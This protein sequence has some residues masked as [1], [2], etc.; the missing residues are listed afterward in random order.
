MHG[1]GASEFRVFSCDFVDRPIGGNKRTIREIT[2][3]NH[4]RTIVDSGTFRLW[5]EVSSATNS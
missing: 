1:Q 3:I 5:R 4:E 2:R